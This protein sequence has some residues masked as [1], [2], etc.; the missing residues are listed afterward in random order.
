MSAQPRAERML[1]SLTITIALAAGALGALA[2]TASAACSEVPGAQ[3]FLPFGDDRLY[4]P[5]PGGDFTDLLGSGWELSGGAE[6]AAATQPDG[7]IGGVLVLPSSGRATSPVMCVT[8]D[9][10]RA[11][12]WVQNLVGP[13]GVSFHVSY[14]E[15]GVWTRSKTTGRF[16]GAR[17]DWELSRMI[18]VHPLNSAEWQEV[19]FTFVAGGRNSRFL[20]DDFWVDPFKRG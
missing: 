5:V 1:R 11:R 6:I 14:R 15:S 9:Y 4:V 16:H 12:L 20:V 2:G 7:S 13:G 17:T 3:P 19:R 18:S 10:P 8:R